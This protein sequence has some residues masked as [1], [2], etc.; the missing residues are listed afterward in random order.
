MQCQV[1]WNL[2]LLASQHKGARA[3]YS[4]KNEASEP[5]GE[6][7]R[8][9]QHRVGLL[10]FL[11][12]SK[13]LVFHLGHGID[14]CWILR[15]SQHFRRACTAPFRRTRRNRFRVGLLTNSYQFNPASKFCLQRGSQAILRERDA[16]HRTVLSAFARNNDARSPKVQGVMHTSRRAH[17]SF[18]WA[19]PCDD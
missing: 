10:L 3:D 8:A 1:R 4:C 12:F 7:Q 11:F 14:R 17:R 15:V 16:R 5:R 13:Q 6:A 2:I 9:L 19:F 18:G